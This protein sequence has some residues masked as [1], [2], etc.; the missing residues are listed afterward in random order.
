MAEPISFPS[1]TKNAGLPLLFSGQSQKEFFLNQS[2]E[3]IDALLSKAVEATLND[4]PTSPNDGE[5]YLIGSNPT[6]NW[7]SRK[8]EIAVRIAGSWHFVT[9]KEGMEL[10][11]RET[12]QTLI[13]RSQW[14][15]P[16]TPPEPADGT[17]ID[18]EARAAIA[19]LI[20]SL[21]SAGL[22][23]EQG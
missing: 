15:R 10:Y 4:P 13:F 2:L 1:T 9:P 16:S 5:C 17:V 12:K 18:T 14:I 19:Q 22:L 3:T 8:D 20:N 21:K 7:A 6:A 23:S 11:D